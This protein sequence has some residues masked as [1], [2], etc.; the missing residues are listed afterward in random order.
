MLLHGNA[1]TGH[2]EHGL[3]ESCMA[4][5]HLQAV[6]FKAPWEITAYKLGTSE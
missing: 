3:N 5:L 2:A 1:M 6:D 4:M